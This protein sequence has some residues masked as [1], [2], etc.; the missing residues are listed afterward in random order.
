MTQL[1]V[2]TSNLDGLQ[3]AMAVTT[4]PPLARLPHYAAAIR[5]TT[6]GLD[7]RRHSGWRQA[8][9]GR[10]ATDGGLGGV[11]ENREPNPGTAKNLT[12]CQEQLKQLDV[13]MSNFD[14][15]GVGGGGGVT[16]HN[17]HHTGRKEC[18]ATNSRVQV[19]FHHLGNNI[20]S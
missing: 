14:G 5:T 8:G 12:C 19:V 10:V 3:A 2:V 11:A 9:G 16:G 17:V 1:D 18:E 15:V 4:D 20:Y 6:L 13:V 7:R